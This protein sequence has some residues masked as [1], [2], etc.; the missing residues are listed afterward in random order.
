MPELLFL[1][2]FFVMLLVTGVSLTGM[3]I[4]VVV[5]AV[6]MVVGGLLVLMMKLLPWLLLAIAGVWVIR[7]LRASKTPC[8]RGSNRR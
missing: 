1:T 7:A 5:A 8:C 2:G 4:A 6:L 3:L